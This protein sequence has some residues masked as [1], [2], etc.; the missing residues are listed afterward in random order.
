MG[1]YCWKARDSKI[2][3]GAARTKKGIFI[4]TSNFSK[5]AQEYASLIENKIVL[6]DS[7]QL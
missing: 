1:K 2:C 5:E 6:I 3:R 4:A 7:E